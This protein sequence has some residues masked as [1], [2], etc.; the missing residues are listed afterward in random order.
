[1]HAWEQIQITV[2]YI[3]EHLS[4][5]IHIHELATLASLSPFYY[6]RLF[7]RLVKKPVNEYMKLRR[8]AWASDALLKPNQRIMDVALAIGFSSHEVFTRA[9]KDVYRMTPEQYRS[10]PVQLNHF[11]KP[12]L[13]LHYTLIDEHSPLIAD[14]MVLEFSRRT[15]SSSQFFI[16][17]TAQQPMN[18]MPAGC[19]PGVDVLGQLW[20][21]FHLN[22][23]DIT[24]LSL[25]GDEIG[26]SYAGTQADH[27]C[28]FAGAE[29]DSG[30][31]PSGFQSWELPPGEYIICTFEGENFEHLV[32]DALYKAQRY[33]YETWLPRHK[34][35]VK[36]F[37][38]E[39][40]AS[41]HDATTRMELWVMCAD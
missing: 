6:Q 10:T 22:K 41:H 30:T 36:P 33:L 24:Q 11:N 23:P 21:T 16:G 38:V 20:N 3:E 37:L 25:N 32:M 1:M 28:Y 29:A 5:E 2:D 26:V 14:N 27:F 7:R 8:L 40:Y 19:E 9:F 15:L 31:V 34:L 12:Q 17:L 39:R 35:Q 18:E 4:E 13:L